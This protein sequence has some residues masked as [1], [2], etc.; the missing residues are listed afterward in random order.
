VDSA[1]FFGVAGSNNDVNVLNQ[2]SLF[3]GVLKGEAPNVNFMVM[4]MSTTRVHATD[5]EVFAACHECA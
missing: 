2:S 5:F 3:T 4:A 1:C